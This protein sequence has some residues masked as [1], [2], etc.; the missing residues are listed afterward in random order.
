MDAQ[1]A[2]A[3]MKTDETDK[4]DCLFQSVL[5]GA[6]QLPDAAINA[7]PIRTAA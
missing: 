5:S 7:A 1:K 4:A 2:I 3:R 6:R